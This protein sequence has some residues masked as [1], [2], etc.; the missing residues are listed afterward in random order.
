MKHLKT[1]I[2]AMVLFAAF[3]C[4]KNQAEV[5]GQV[6]FSVANDPRV[7]EVTKSNVSDFTALPAQ[8]DFTI[9]I[10]DADGAKKWEGKLSEWDSSFP[11]AAGEYSVE[12]VYGDLED[13]GFDK[14]YFAGEQTFRVTGGETTAVS[15][16]VNLKNTIVRISC[17]EYFRK[18]YTD[19]TFKLTRDGADVVTFAKDET[20]AA[21][22][23]GYKITV[24]GTLTSETKTQTFSANY[25]GLD[26]GTAYTIAFDVKNAG[27]STITISFNDE[28]VEA[29][30]VVIE[31]ND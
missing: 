2:G 9:T 7:E 17:S 25:N 22:I 31:L 30:L 3:S 18:Y 1:F 14:P 13:E 27:G 16:Q 28:V 4:T 20:R 6:S 5:N 12:A 29:P 21:F 26:E 23:D 8:G 11:L 24:E 19:Y 10:F 15:L